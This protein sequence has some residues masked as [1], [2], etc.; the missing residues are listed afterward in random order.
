MLIDILIY[1]RKRSTKLAFPS[2]T[3][4]RNANSINVVLT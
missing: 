4:M 3:L 2:P 1:P